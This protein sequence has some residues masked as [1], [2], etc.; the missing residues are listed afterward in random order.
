MKDYTPRDIADALDYAVL[1]P[2]AT[3]EDIRDGCTFANKH[4]LKSICVASG[5][6]ELAAKLHG[7]VCAV[8][9][10]PHGNTTPGIKYMET[11]GVIQNGARELDVVINYGRY[12]GGDR[13]II[14]QDL[15]NICNYAR[16]NGVIVKAILESCYYTPSQLTDACRRC[17]FA[18]VHFVKTSTGFGK[19]GATAG[20]VEIMLR[21]IGDLKVDVKASGEI[22]NYG[23]AQ[24]LLDLGCTRIGA[25]RYLEL[26]HG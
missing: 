15:R 3:L 4:K 24:K 11:I 10:F 26:C 13:Y 19:S 16:A 7:N 22:K 2:M 5:N 14:E 6:V 12:L 23:D 9:G 21:A 1:N 17:V 25:S 20:D 18:G 8:V